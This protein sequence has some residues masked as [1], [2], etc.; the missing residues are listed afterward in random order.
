MGDGAGKEKRQKISGNCGAG[1]PTSP[2]P[3][4]DPTNN[5]LFGYLLI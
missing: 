4:N 2:V 5:T 3:P 1:S